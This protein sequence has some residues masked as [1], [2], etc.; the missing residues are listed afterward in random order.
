MSMHVEGQYV[1]HTLP[2]VSYKDFIDKEYVLFAKYDIHR[3]IPNLMDGLKPSQRKVLFSC[4]KRKLTKDVKVAQLSGYVSE[5]AAYH[6]GEVS[7]QTTIVNMAQDYVGANNI[8]V[9]V[10]SGQF[11]T[12]MQGGKDAASA[13]YIFTRLHEVTRKIFHPDDDALL[14][15]QDEEGQRI[16]PKHYY[17]IIP[18]V[19]CNGAEGIGTGWS[20]YIPNFSPRE[21]INCVRSYITKTKPPELMPWYR[22]FKGEIRPAEDKKAFSVDGKLEVSGTTVVIKELP[23]KKWTQDYKEWLQKLLPAAQDDASKA[24]IEDFREYHTENTVHFVVT[25]TQDQMARAQEKGLLTYFRLNG[26]LSCQN[27]VLWTPEGNIKRYEEVAEIVAAFCPVR[28]NYYHKRKANLLVKLRRECEILKQKV[29]FIEEVI[30]GKLI[31]AKK[32]KDVLLHELNT[33]NYLMKRDINRKYFDEFTNPAVAQAVAEDEGDAAA[34]PN[35][36]G[37]TAA[38]VKGG[39]QGYEYLLGMTL[40]S[41]TAEK[42]AE[43]R[44]Q[45]ET[46][47]R[48]VKQLE[49]T[50]PEDIWDNDLKELEKCIDEIAARD[51]INANEEEKLAKNSKRGGKALS[52]ADVTRRKGIAAKRRKAEIQKEDVAASDSEDSPKGGMGKKKAKLDEAQIAQLVH[53]GTA[54]ENQKDFLTR[55]AQRHKERAAIVQQAAAAAGAPANAHVAGGGLANG[56]AGGAATAPNR[57][58]ANGVVPMDVS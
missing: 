4:F 1:D 29:R 23:I 45:F 44:A 12:R 37:G 31:V 40:W 42:A 16:E 49:G 22:N 3:M 43:L 32:K 28:L 9:L 35:A 30:E 20:T 46:K 50:A 18:F 17:P 33:K 15:Y 36:A 39:G 2:S 27:L 41:L 56:L 57:P 38:E 8:N 21:L 48:E 54:A 47:E 7:L 52:R 53:P 5:H 13:R 26:S 6:H 25:L 34:G 24:S 14:D 10:P 19:L 51:R 58:V 55:L 11:G